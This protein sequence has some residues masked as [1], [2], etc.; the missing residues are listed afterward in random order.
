MSDGLSIEEKITQ[1]LRKNQEF[2]YAIIG[3]IAAALIGAAIWAVVT[4]STNYQIGYMA[5]GVG[6][7]A[8]F[9][10]RFFGA[11]VD[12]QYRVVGAACALLG[13][14]LGN[15]FSQVW[16]VAES[17]SL[18]YFETLGYLNFEIIRNLFQ[19]TFSFMDVLFYGI[20]IYEGYR[21][22]VRE[23]SD[24]MIQ[25]YTTTGSVSK[26]SN[27]NLRLPIAIVCFISIGVLLYFVSSQGSGVKT[28]FYDS[29]EKMSE[30]ELVD[31]KENGTWTY[32]YASGQVQLISNFKSGLAHGDWQW[33]NEEGNATRKASFAGGLQHGPDIYFFTNGIASDSGNYVNGR[34]EGI[35]V[36]KNQAGMITATGSY[37]H[38]LEDGEW[39][40][41]HD[42]GYLSAQGV[43]KK[44]IRTGAWKFWHQDKTLYQEAEYLDNGK[45]D[46]INAWDIS[47]K[48]TL[49]NGNGTLYT[50][51]YNGTVQGMFNVKNRKRTGRW[52]SYRSDGSKREEGDFSDDLERVLTT[53]NVAGEPVIKNGSGNYT[54]FYDSAEQIV[55]E[56]GL[57]QNG[58]R[59]GLW[60]Q[61]Y[62]PS[63]DT[64]QTATYVHGKM[65][66]LIRIY[67]QGGVLYSQ[68]KMVDDKREG[69]WTWFDG[70]GVQESS[71]TFIHGM[72]DGVQYFW[73]ADG[74]ITKEELY[75]DDELMSVKLANEISDDE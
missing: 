60:I 15:I 34:K 9:A 73:D 54:S 32:W 47:G 55:F 2:G 33:F 29:G 57:L 27:S 65:N 8:G 10:V 46:F 50:Y 18:G 39:L 31:G 11:G 7:L 4:V 13:C 17:E 72:K 5:V 16:F 20:A 67:Q 40:N 25:E 43:L 51:N 24:E 62:N 49:T 26:P 64:L 68:G 22:A 1:E 21:F 23:V 58:L 71:V 37:L 3:G 28:F 36:Y 42:N 74:N 61:F 63:G 59:E 48:Q 35:W 66:G 45:V 52:V 69:Q 30:G 70:N 41:F 38:D 44:G 14:M 56:T 19:E 53:W 75:K 12:V 6:L